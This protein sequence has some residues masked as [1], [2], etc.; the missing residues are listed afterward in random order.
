MSRR[1]WRGAGFRV[2]YLFLTLMRD[3]MLA[4]RVEIVS[5]CNETETWKVA[6]PFPPLHTSVLA[7][8]YF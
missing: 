3:E 4:D 2:T 5:G 8:P 1:F 6:I 7:P